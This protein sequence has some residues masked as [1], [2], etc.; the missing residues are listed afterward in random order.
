VLSPTTVLAVVV[1]VAIGCCCVEGNAA[2]DGVWDSSRGLMGGSWAGD[3]VGEV[4]GEEPPGL[5]A[6]NGDEFGDIDG[7]VSGVES[8]NRW[9]QLTQ[10][11][12]KLPL[13]TY[14]K[15]R[16]NSCRPDE[17]ANDIDRSRFGRL[18][19]SRAAA[20][21]PR[22]AGLMRLPRA[23]SSYSC[24]APGVRTDYVRNSRQHQR[25]GGKSR[26]TSRATYSRGRAES[27]DVSFDLCSTGLSRVAP[28][29]DSPKPAWVNT[30]CPFSRCQ[31]RR[32]EKTKLGTLSS[33]PL[34]QKQV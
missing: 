9:Y 1:M 20:P 6:S 12:R 32:V 3:S 19:N 10:A 18:D 4:S 15:R 26:G 13:A 2:R 24:G 14:S 34:V 17:F 25:D 30:S 11:S 29:S 22:Y 28:V 27:P 7:C 31:S 16:L 21:S 8:E 33:A 23:I 5:K